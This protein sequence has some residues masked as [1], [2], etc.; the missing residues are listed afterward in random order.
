MDLPAP[1]NKKPP[2]EQAQEQFE[3]W[4][5]SRAKLGAIPDALWQ[6]AVMLFP[7]YPCASNIKNRMGT[8]KLCLKPVT[9]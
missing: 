1:A 6:A 3:Q 2:L 8:G 7:D 5:R 4:R 9:V